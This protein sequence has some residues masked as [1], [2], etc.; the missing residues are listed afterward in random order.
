MT[1]PAP[2][3]VVQL[4]ETLTEKLNWYV[5]AATAAGVGT[6]AATTPSAEARVVYT[7]ANIRVDQVLLFPDP[8]LFALNTHPTLQI[9]RDS[10]CCGSQLIVSEIW[11]R[12]G[13]GVGI[14]GTGTTYAAALPKGVKVGPRDRFFIGGLMA[15]HYCSS[16]SGKSS[17]ATRGPWAN[18]GKGVKN[19]YLGVKFTFGGQTRYGWARLTVYMPG[20]DAWLTGYAYETVPNKPIITGK[21]KGPDVV[22]VHSGTLGSLARGRQ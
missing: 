9:L 22:T 6:L 15:E 14:V 19:R 20:I 12:Y 1:S 11:P 21:T 18:G 5:V 10:D 3:K 2:R 13:S 16:S 8:L 4:S 7:P 17:C